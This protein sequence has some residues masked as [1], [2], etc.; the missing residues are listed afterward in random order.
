MWFLFY[1]LMKHSVKFKIQIRPIPNIADIALVVA[2]DSVIA[3][4]FFWAIS[5]C[6]VLQMGLCF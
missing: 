3:Y 4:N 2:S 6:Y 1:T 5:V